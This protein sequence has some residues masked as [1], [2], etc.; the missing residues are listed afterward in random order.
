MSP[1]RT[2]TPSALTVAALAPA[3]ALAADIDLRRAP[4]LRL[5][6]A[7][8]ATLSFPTD[9]RLTPRRGRHVPGAHR[10]RGSRQKSS[11]HR[12]PA[13]RSSPAMTPG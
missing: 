5:V 7:N 4:S 6:D 9:D 10:L 11:R 13:P 1:I 12:P 3:V 8:H 2:I